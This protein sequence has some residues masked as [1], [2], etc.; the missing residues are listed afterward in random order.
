M[1]STLLVIAPDNFRDEELFETKKVLSDSGI[2]TVIASKGVT[3]A[4]GM[5][6]GVAEVERDIKN[7]DINEY[8]GIVF[9]GGSGT[10]VLFDDPVAIKL[11]QEA[12]KNNK[13]TAAICIAP[14]ILAKANIVRGKKITSSISEKEVLEA[15][16]AVYT[17]NEVQVDGNIISANGP[18]S[19]QRFGFE[20]AS[21]LKAQK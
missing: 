8:S 16:G 5:L 11:A 12:S 2:S 21:W 9:I 18:A 7:V 10:K 17:N 14:T 6:G 19:A 4:T 3:R 13:L 1:L 15:A 20:I